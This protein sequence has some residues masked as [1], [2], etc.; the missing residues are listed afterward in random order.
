[1][2]ATSETLIAAARAAA[3]RAQ[4]PYSS[5]PVGAAVETE[6]GAIVLGCNIESAS[7]GLTICA[8][9]V[10][11]FAALAAGERP[12]RIAVTCLR[13][14]PSVPMSL[15]PCGAC[16][17][18]IL[19]QLGPDALVIIDRVGE[20]TV[21]DLLPYGFRWMIQSNFPRQGT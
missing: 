14:D 3:E 15:T 13:G 18:V 20:F 4:A 10:A 8:E 19:D 9:R 16:R 5:F 2:T 1:M 6:S 7:Y 11:I 21:D 17:Q 12:V